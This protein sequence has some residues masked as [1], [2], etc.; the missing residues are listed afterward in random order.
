MLELA[1][2][3]TDGIRV[4]RDE[5]WVRIQV[6]D[7]GAGISEEDRARVLEPFE[8]GDSDDVAASS[9]G[10]GLPLARTIAR[11]HGGNLELSSNQPRGLLA[12]MLLPR[13]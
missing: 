12:T 4:L 6:W 8:R 5:D 1:Q 7:H 11:A 3:S 9:Q 13:D 2:K 10:L